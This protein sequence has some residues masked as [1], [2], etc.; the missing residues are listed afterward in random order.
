MSSA[1][2][3]VKYI[4]LSQVQVPKKFHIKEIIQDEARKLKEYYTKR[5]SQTR[6]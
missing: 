1:D 5:L 2:K 3:Q 6:G 4:G